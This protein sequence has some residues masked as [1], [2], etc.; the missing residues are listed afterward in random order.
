[1]SPRAL[2]RQPRSWPHY[3]C[4]ERP[5]A[6]ALWKSIAVE[7][8]RQ[9]WSVEE[10][11]EAAGVAPAIIRDGEAGRPSGLDLSAWRVLSAMGLVVVRV[12]FAG[13][14]EQPRPGGR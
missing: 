6:V 2:I 12:D 13:G 10:L 4:A 5:A 7:R 8:H 11:A 3:E 14:A 9:G 1:M